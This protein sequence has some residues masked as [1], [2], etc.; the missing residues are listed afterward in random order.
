[1]GKEIIESGSREDEASLVEL[2]KENDLS[3][4]MSD[5]G[6]EFTDGFVRSLLPFNSYEETEGGLNFAK[7]SPYQ[8]LRPHTMGIIAG[9]VACLVW[10]PQY[11]IFKGIPSCYGM[12]KAL[13]SE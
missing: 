5:A 11:A 1:M 7:L 13:L 6:K 3:I 4:V 10:S 2:V 12:A 9:N 8:F